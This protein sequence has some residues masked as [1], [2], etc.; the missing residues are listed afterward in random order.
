MR[1]FDD[2]TLPGFWQDPISAFQRSF[3]NAQRIQSSPDGGIA[4]LGYHALR[5]IGMHPAIDG[6][7]MAP[8]CE[9]EPRGVYEVLRHGLFTQVAPDHRRSRKA[10]LAGLNGGTVRSFAPQARDLARRRL[11]ELGSQPFDLFRDLCLPFAAEA[12]AAFLGYDPDQAQSLAEEVETF[13]RQLVFNADPSTAGAADVAAA[14]LLE[15]TRSILTSG[16]DRLASRMANALGDE[17]GTGLVAS[18]LFDAIDTAAAGLAGTLAILLHEAPD[19]APLRDE[20]F[21]EQAIEEALRLATPAVFTVRQAR[22]DVAFGDVAI[23]QGAMVWMWWSAGNCDPEAFPAPARFQPGRGNRSLPFGIGAHSCVGHGWTKQ[24]THILVEIGLT[25]EGGLS[26]LSPG[27][28][29]EIGGA[30]RPR[31]QMVACR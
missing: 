23:P 6:T 15:R 19:R 30:R 29:W 11:S 18:L 10:V 4:V 17:N 31:G 3:H 9:G 26:M 2:F 12:W 25:G 21:R 27:L 20:N 28:T 8:P 22:E 24:L 5:A 14:S 7:P 16:G 13:S 1:R